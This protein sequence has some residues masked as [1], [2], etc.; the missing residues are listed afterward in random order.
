MDEPLERFLQFAAGQEADLEKIIRPYPPDQPS[1][2]VTVAKKWIANTV[3]YETRAAIRKKAKAEEEKRGIKSEALNSLA[4]VLKSSPDDEYQDTYN[5]RVCQKL[6]QIETSGE[7]IPKG[8]AKLE[9]AEEIVRQEIELTISDQNLVDYLASKIQKQKEARL[10]FL[11]SAGLKILENP[12]LTIDY[13]SLMYEIQERE[14]DTSWPGGKLQNV[15][16]TGLRGESINLISMLCCINKFNLAG[17]YTLVPDLDA[18]LENP[19]LEPVPL[20]VDEL[21]AVKRFFEFYEIKA[22]LTIYISDT[23]YT[24]VGQFG[25]VCPENLRN[26]Q[27]YLENLGAYVTSKN[28]AVKVIPISALTDNNLQYEEV[29]ARVLANVT[30]F[31]DTDFE[32]EWYRKF[33]TAMEKVY[34][35]QAKRKLFSPAEMRRKALEITRMI[36]AVNAAQGAVFATLGSDTILIST[37]RRERDQN[38]IIDKEARSG[39]PATIYI[40]KAA[41][42]WNRKLTGKI[43]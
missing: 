16:T 9:Y 36:W 17:G 25:S 40:L 5:R 15:I 19:K 22:N 23:D 27:V 2:E 41:E 42:R 24:E 10:K 33:E 12:E 37:E 13:A 35:T 43:D 34:E 7:P 29:K 8:Q 14:T 3:S 30:K 26:L 21:L 18:Y 20:I 28:V 38:Y 1:E 6:D 32:R 31:K 4:G 11:L 39:F